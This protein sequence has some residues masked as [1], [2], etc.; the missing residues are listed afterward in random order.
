MLAQL[1]DNIAW[2]RFDHVLDR[3]ARVADRRRP[4]QFEKCGRPVLQY[5]DRKH[6][7]PI[8][9]T[10]E[11][12]DESLFDHRV[13]R[14]PTDRKARQTGRPVD[15]RERLRPGND[16]GLGVDIAGLRRWPDCCCIKPG[17]GA[18]LTEFGADRQVQAHLA[19]CVDAPLVRCCTEQHEVLIGQPGNQ[20]II[21]ANTQEPFTH[22]GEV[23]NDPDHVGNGSRDF[24]FDVRQ[25]VGMAAVQ[26]DLR[27]RFH[28]CP[29]RPSGAP[30][31]HLDQFVIAISNDR[32][33][34]VN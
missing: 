23:G 21:C 25:K 12:A 32:Q 1:E 30:L 31:D 3:S 20:R 10:P 4:G 22:L 26:P 18:V 7:F 27:P 19:D 17:V 29:E 5:R 16:H 34:W 8:C 2:Q 28:L 15:G 6:A 14:G 11:Q 13:V 24:V 9:A 33:H